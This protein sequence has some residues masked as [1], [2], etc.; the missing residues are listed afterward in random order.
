MATKDVHLWVVSRR[1]LLVAVSGRVQGRESPHSSISGSLGLA[2]ASRDQQNDR[3][4][5]AAIVF[6]TSVALTCCNV[7]WVLG[8]LFL[9]AG[10]D[11][12]R[13]CRYLGIRTREM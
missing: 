5:V 13:S 8:I 7:Y 12:L 2:L 4:A 3:V 9:S 1:V 11:L 6:R 10:A